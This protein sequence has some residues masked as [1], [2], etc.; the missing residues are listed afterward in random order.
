MIYRKGE[1]I[2]EYVF[3]SGKLILL[4]T[5]V[6]LLDFSIGRI[7]S[8][9]YFKQECGRQYRATFSIEKT[10]DDILIFG[11]SR[12][13]H[14]YVPGVFENDL[15]LSCYNTGSPGQFL[16]YSYAILK[17]N[18]KRHTPKIIILDV[19]DG[20]LRIERESYD[21]LSFLLPY[22]KTHEEM[23][24]IIDLKSPM[25]K[26]KLL[27]S[28]YAF[29]SSFLMIAGGNSDYF[30][31]KF[32]D[33]NGYKPLNGIWNAPID[34][35]NSESYILDTIKIN[36]FNSFIRDCKEKNIK[37]FV[38]CSPIFLKY[39]QR[40]NSI[41]KLEKI[42]KGQNLIFFDFSNDTTFINHPNLFDD[43][44]HLNGKGSE[45]FSSILASKIKN[46]L[47]LKKHSSDSLS[48]VLSS[49]LSKSRF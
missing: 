10:E 5:I 14:Q 24:S 37:L 27:S 21:R 49:L 46:S 2:S 38:V 19:T 18:L 7:L 34:K 29:N 12:A 39:T 22:Y 26:Y 47:E 45:L 44:A 6:F 23:R 28:I 25:E 3:F 41:I 40:E 11:S 9:Y 33:T 16:L 43:A 17:A 4:F 32:T 1:K 36:V 20:E 31:R 48:G 35:G 15:K 13:Y 8:Y 42:T 30:K